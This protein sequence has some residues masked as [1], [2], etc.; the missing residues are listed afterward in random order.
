MR[1]GSTGPY[2]MLRTMMRSGS[3][4][5]AVPDNR[6]DKLLCH[7]ISVQYRLLRKQL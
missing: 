5:Q 7:T 3:I 1:I 2:C 6:L 4:Y